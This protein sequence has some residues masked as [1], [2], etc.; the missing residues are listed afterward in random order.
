VK[1]QVMVILID[2]SSSYTFFN[3]SLAQKLQV[4]TTAITP[5][6]VKVDNRASLPCTAKV[7]DFEWWEQGYAFS[8]NAKIIDMGA[9]D[10]VLGM[11]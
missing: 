10:L 6:L 1:N 2:S 11:D 9:Y 8:M 3:S 4:A 5:M 7:K